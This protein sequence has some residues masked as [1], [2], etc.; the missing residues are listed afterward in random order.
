MKLVGLV[1]LL[2]AFASD[3]NANIGSVTDT[4]GTS[5][6]IIRGKDKLNGGKGAGVESMDT[7][8]TGVCEA[9]ITFRDNTQVKITNHS[10]LVIDEFVY[11]PKAS[12]AGKLGLRVGMGTVRYASGQIAKNN[13]QKV[14]ITTPTATIAVR[15]TDF[16]M[17]VDEIG[18]S[19]VVLVPS[20]KD[21]KDIKEYEMQENTCLVG[22]ITVSTQAGSVTLDQAF[23]A[24]YVV[25]NVT[26]PT[27]PVTVNIV[28]SKISNTLILV[29]PIEV[30]RAIRDSIKTAKDREVEDTEAEF[31]RRLAQRI[32]ET[33]DQIAQAQMLLM[34]NL[35][36]TSGCNPT[37]SV[38]VVWARPDEQ[39][40]QN[41]GI[42]VAVRYTENEHY[43]E[44]KTQGYESN[45]SITI[46]HNDATATTVI[47]NGSPGGN[48][49]S[50]RQS[51]GV[52]RPQ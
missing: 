17:T 13:P 50:I 2:L 9:Y 27:V 22:S 18:R 35:A 10:K 19:L 14:N 21:Q 41:K 44:V 34:A 40:P 26:P 31:A 8:M 49:I 42:G 43:S 15:G 12:D 1:V 48:V 36:G 16:T 51:S 3:A 33:A 23:Q 32:K 5:C 30:Q 11:D 52:R 25:T 38:C 6:D 29:H 37:T 47:G 4:K 46:T 39:D 45:T 20:C 28:E 7:Y 24:T